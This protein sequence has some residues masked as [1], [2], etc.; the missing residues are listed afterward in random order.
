M[1]INIIESN[2]VKGKIYRYRLNGSQ[3]LKFTG[4]KDQFIIY[5]LSIGEDRSQFTV[6]DNMGTVRAIRRDLDHNWVYYPEDNFR[7]GR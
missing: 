2:L 3:K 4:H 6:V 5:F 7:F 1:K